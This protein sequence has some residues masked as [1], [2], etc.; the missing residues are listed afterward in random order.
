MSHLVCGP[1]VDVTG[2]SG[3]WRRVPSRL[4]ISECMFKVQVC[5]EAV[6]I[7]N[8]HNFLGGGNRKMTG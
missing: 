5:R 4:L 8:D 6:F 2:R 3:G 7:T 1:A